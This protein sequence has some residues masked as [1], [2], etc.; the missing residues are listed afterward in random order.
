M[1]IG[2]FWVLLLLLAG[3]SVSIDSEDVS[4]DRPEWETGDSWTFSCKGGQSRE[5]RIMSFEVLGKEE[6]KD[7][8]CYVL[9]TGDVLREYYTYDLNPRARLAGD[10]VLLEVIPELRTFEWPLN[11]TGKKWKTTY[12]LKRY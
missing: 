4:V 11:T 7:T 10:T 1:K 8:P 12:A 2:V 6:F 3:C 9:K 5:R